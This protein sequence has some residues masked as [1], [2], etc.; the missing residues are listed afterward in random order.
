MANECAGHEAQRLTA[1]RMGRVV[2]RAHPGQEPLDGQRAA[3]V[4]VLGCLIIARPTAL[5]HTDGAGHRPHCGVPGKLSVRAFFSGTFKGPRSLFFSARLTLTV[6]LSCQPTAAVS[7]PSPIQ[8]SSLT[9]KALL[10]IVLLELAYAPMIVL[11]VYVASYMFSRSETCQR[12]A[13]GNVCPAAPFLRPW[14]LTRFTCY[15]VRTSVWMAN[16]RT[17]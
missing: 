6:T 13:A 7:R 5:F 12:C 17:G 8:I 3:A 2:M 11:M 14:G 16:G 15:R 1:P 4:G 10:P 9:G